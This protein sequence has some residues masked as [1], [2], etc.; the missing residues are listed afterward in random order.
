MQEK[1][2]IGTKKICTSLLVTGMRYSEL[3]RFRENQNWL[4][5]QFIYLPRGSMLKVKAKQK[6]FIL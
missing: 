5:G 1:T 2:G 6:E 3:E 4:E